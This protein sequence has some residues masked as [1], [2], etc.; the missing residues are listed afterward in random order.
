MIYSVITLIQEGV[1][2]SFFQVV[3]NCLRCFPNFWAF[4]SWLSA[5]TVLLW[6]SYKWIFHAKNTTYQFRSSEAM[7]I[8]SLL[9]WNMVF[10]YSRGP[11]G[12]E[13]Y[14]LVVKFRPGHLNMTHRN[15]KVDISSLQTTLR[16]VWKVT[17]YFGWFLKKM[18][19]MARMVLQCQDM[20][21]GC[22]RS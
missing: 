6:T 12:P 13:N 1:I 3:G 4:L 19:K 21:P 14:P 17:G 8:N 20:V 5:V 11:L 10:Y 18:T 2:E 7:W 22:L 15:L 16:Q 9:D